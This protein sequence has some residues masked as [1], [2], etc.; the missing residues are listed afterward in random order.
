MPTKRQDILDNIR[1]ELLAIPE[2]SHV[3]VNVATPVNL[4]T[5]P[6]PACFIDSGVE[7]QGAGPFPVDSEAWDWEVTVQVWTRGTDPEELL[8]L[9]YTK[10]MED[11][12]RGGK[13]VETRRTGAEL[14]EVDPS[15]GLL[16]MVV[17]FRILYHH[18]RGSP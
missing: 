1:T 17:P 15:G 5:V 9:V 16:A 13:A 14:I 3:E 8:G 7:T 10:L 4:S 12:R 6:L 11:P 18:P 2:I